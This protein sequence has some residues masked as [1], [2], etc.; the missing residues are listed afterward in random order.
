LQIEI[1][2]SILVRLHSSS[3]GR[4]HIL[5]SEAGRGAFSRMILAACSGVLSA[6]AFKK[7]LISIDAGHAVWQGGKQSPQWSETSKVTHIFL[8]ALI[9]G[10][11]AV[12]LIPSLTIVA[13]EGTR[14]PFP[15]SIFTTQTKQLV[16][17]FKPSALQKTGIS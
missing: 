11:S 10:D 8:A 7:L 2:C 5:P 17:G 12:M 1:G 15:P 6:I 3:Q 4:G 14:F 16:K 9:S 13:H